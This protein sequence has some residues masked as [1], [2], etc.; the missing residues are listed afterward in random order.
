MQNIT[1]FVIKREQQ[2][3]AEKLAASYIDS[4]S[5]DFW[6]HLAKIRGTGKNPSSSVYG[7]S[8]NKGVAN[9]FTEYYNETY[10]SVGFDEEEI[11]LLYHVCENVS[12]CAS[13][14][15]RHRIN[16]ASVSH[17]I[18]TLNGGRNDGFY[19][20]TS[21]FILNGTDLLCQHLPNFFSLMLF[22][23]ISPCR[24]ACQL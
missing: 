19:G 20:L 5:S 24:F 18:H 3:K 8:D 17:S 2:L 9:L 15:H 14:D 10:N 21:D 13:T 22:H 6:G 23:C 16:H 1:L 4:R 12:S 11:Q 7:I